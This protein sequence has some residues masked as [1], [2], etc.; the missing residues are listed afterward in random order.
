MQEILD[1][2]LIAAVVAA[3]GLVLW[4]LENVGG[5]GV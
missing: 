2:L 1:T 4:A 3:G 5:V